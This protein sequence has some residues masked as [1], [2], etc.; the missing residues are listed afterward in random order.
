MGDKGMIMYCIPLHDG[1]ELADAVSE[2]EY[3][4]SRECVDEIGEG[5]E[6][7]HVESNSSFDV[8]MKNLHCHHLILR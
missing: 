6:Q 4:E 2:T 5:G 8:R 1:N 7:L 3:L